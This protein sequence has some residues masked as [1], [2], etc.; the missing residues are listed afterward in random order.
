[1]PIQIGSATLGGAGSVVVQGVV[2]DYNEQGV[3]YAKKYVGEAGVPQDIKRLRRQVYDVMR[4]MGTP[5]LVKHMYNDSDVAAGLALRS[6]NYDSVYGQTRNRDPLSHGVGYVSIETSDN[7]WVMSDG[8]LVKS[9][10]RPDAG[11]VPAPKHR[12]FG[13]S[14]LIY[15]IEPDA[16][17]DRFKVDPTGALIKVQEAT[18]QAPWFPEINDNDLIIN[19]EVDR[20][21]NVVAAHERFQAKM[22]TPTSIRGFG[23]RFGRREYTE[24]GGNRYVV[25]Q[26]FQMALLPPTDE[27][28]NVET[29]R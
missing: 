7:E 8:T 5:V 12:G 19:V 4:H 29:D 1:M 15:I 28:N 14:Y 13:P 11:A 25:N 27:M 22:S 20:A 10:T 17:E 3:L 24:D 21:H 16:A 2:Y 26:S 23:D 9:E 18:A 6:D